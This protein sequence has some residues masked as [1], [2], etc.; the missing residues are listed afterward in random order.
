M[1]SFNSF[2]ASVNCDTFIWSLLTSWLAF[3]R[4]DCC[5]SLK[6]FKRSSMDSML[7][8]TT[9]FKSSTDSAS[10]ALSLKWAMFF[11][12]SFDKLCSLL[13]S[14]V[15]LSWLV[16]MMP[17]IS[18]SRFWRSE[19]YS[20]YFSC[21]SNFILTTSSVT[22]DNKSRPP[23][24]WALPWDK[25]FTSFDNSSIWGLF[26][27]VWLI[28]LISCWMLFAMFLEAITRSDSRTVPTPSLKSLKCSPFWTRLSVSRSVAKVSVIF[29]L[30]LKYST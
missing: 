21:S 18:S 28:F 26:F 27:S 14:S 6:S 13:E 25:T 23:K 9:V 3:S 17:E 19:K 10:S 7:E 20:L 15:W 12:K 24:N 1:A 30:I 16:L 4:K 11:S 29:W 22:R 5:F 2:C 8:N